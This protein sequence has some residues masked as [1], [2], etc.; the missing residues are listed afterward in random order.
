M[1]MAVDVGNSQTM[2]GLI[3]DGRIEARWRMAT[4]ARLTADEIRAKI[5]VLLAADGRSWEKIHGVALASVVPILTIAYVE[6]V[7]RAIGKLP[8]VVG[9][10]L[11]TGLPISYEDPREVGADR[12]V[13]AVGAV[14]S[15]GAPVIVVDFGTATTLDVVDKAGAYVGGVI[16]PGVKTGAD[17]LFRKAARLSAVD[18]EM[19][20]RVIGRSTRE[21]IQVG[22]V[23]G[24]AAMVDGLVRR[25]W[26]EL[27]GP[28]PVIATGGHATE[29]AGACETISEV[30][31]DLTLEGLALLWKRNAHN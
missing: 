8:L 14:A 29:I 13:N 5:G 22:L 24:H 3:E 1:I 27:G 6:L 31:S 10:G 21:S 15:H 19:P 30:N 11:K 20:R 16:A 2:L 26:A 4:D 17:A 23:L 9:P 18:Y 28:C 25:T 7:R 12:I